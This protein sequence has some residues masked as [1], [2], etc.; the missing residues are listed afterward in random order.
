M[1]NDKEMRPMSG[2][3]VETSGIYQDNNGH[4]VRLQAGDTYPMDPQLGKV[5][6]RMVELPLDENKIDNIK[7][8]IEA[9]A[10]SN[11][12]VSAANF[13]EE[14]AEESRRLKHRLHG[15]NR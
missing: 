8:D 10:M 11:V 12:P 13:E 6:Y 7:T 3:R 5:D 2:D 4:E 15:G 9:A 1:A 14:E